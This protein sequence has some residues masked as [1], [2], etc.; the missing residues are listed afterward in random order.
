MSLPQLSIH[1]SEDTPSA[2]LSPIGSSPMDR[3]HGSTATIGRNP[4][5]Q[6]SKSVKNGKSNKNAVVAKKA[7]DLKGS[8]S[9]FMDNIDPIIKVLEGIAQVHPAVAGT[10]AVFSTLFKMEVTRR[11]NDERL[12]ALYVQIKEMMSCL[13]RLKTV[14]LGREM[15][16]LQAIMKE[17]ET[18]ITNCGNICEA[19][20]KKKWAVKALTSMGWEKKLTE[21]GRKFIRRRSEIEQVLTD[22]IAICVGSVQTDV[23]EISADVKFVRE[24]ITIFMEVFRSSDPKPLAEMKELA[25]KKKIGKTSLEKLDQATLK[26]FVAAEKE[27]QHGEKNKHAFTIS[28]LKDELSLSVEKAIDKNWQTFHGKFEF[29]QEQMLDAI[30]KGNREVINAIKEGPHDKVKNE[31]FKALWKEMNWRR[32]VKAR[33]FVT[34]L[35]DHFR[36]KARESFADTNRADDWTLQYIGIHWLHPIMEAFD[37]DYSGY[38]T[39]VELNEFTDSLPNVLGWSMQ[40]W[41]AYWAVGWQLTALHYRDRIHRV[42][43]V[44][45]ALRPR[46]CSE[47]RT[48]IDL[49]LGVVW[50]EVVEI[51]MALSGEKSE[52]PAGLFSKFQAY[53]NHE[54]NRI[55]KNL[56][57]INYNLDTVDDVRAVAGQGRI[58]KYILPLIFLL[59]ER[60]LKLFRVAQNRV[61]QND[62]LEPC[63]EGLFTILEAAQDRVD[64]L[65]ELFQ[66]QR[67]HVGRQFDVV[68][69]GLF[70]YL[71]DSS[72]L[73]SK[74][75]FGAPNFRASE[76][77]EKELEDLQ[78]DPNLE[79]ELKHVLRDNELIE[80]WLSDSELEEQRSRLEA[81]IPPGTP[82]ANDIIEHLLATIPMHFEFVCDGCGTSPIYGA[83]IFCLECRTDTSAVWWHK[84]DFCD[85]PACWTSPP[86]C[87]RPTHDIVKTRIHIQRF[88]LPDLYNNIRKVLGKF[89][90]GPDAADQMTNGVMEGS[91]DDDDEGEGEGE[92]EDM[93]MRSLRRRCIICRHDIRGECWL[94]VECEDCICDFCEAQLLLPCVSC[95]SLFVQPDWYYGASTDDTYMCF[96]C[97]NRSGDVSYPSEEISEESHEVA[98]GGWSSDAGSSDDEDAESYNHNAGFADDHAYRQDYGPE[99]DGQYYEQSP[100]Y[101]DETW[102]WD[103]SYEYGYDEYSD[104]ESTSTE[105]DGGHPLRR[106]THAHPL[107]RLK[108]HI[109]APLQTTGPSIDDRL[110]SVEVK[111]HQMDDKLTQLQQIMIHGFNRIGAL[112]GAN[113]ESSEHGDENEEWQSQGRVSASMVISA[114]S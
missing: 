11:E 83:R 111:G 25:K 108:D 72:G 37:D 78:S 100:N 84:V 46:I 77:D 98:R 23:R 30:R 57:R 99:P 109:E 12:L 101:A 16:D 52:L 26:E 79:T 17:A 114:L 91:G 18:D 38:V 34:T 56:E 74:P 71:H 81:I 15:D 89:R 41:V 13:I 60:H 44:M 69:C 68:A 2:V 7:R 110:T 82:G 67:L 1:L 8:L 63:V 20:K 75:D 90:S 58:E 107:V 54:E 87:H 80:H 102:D 55:R 31:E 106:H 93:P 49:Y 32:N 10:V 96:N 50:T 88:D 113:M 73:W 51:T 42:L 48:Q 53:I 6:R 4:S 86:T 28:D 95:K 62:A 3:V 19:Y 45:H 40:Q 59:L 65:R 35:R 9:T 112:L 76:I 5:L 43:T 64:D 21:L 29:I 85:N 94:C 66:H 92:E 27:L 24:H 47:N 22:Y 70:S 104:E 39:V 36:E 105:E 61:L 33:L 97:S 103:E 14:E